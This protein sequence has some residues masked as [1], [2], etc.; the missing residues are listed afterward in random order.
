[1][2]LKTKN[3]IKD[4]LEEIEKELIAIKVLTQQD[5]TIDITLYHR[6]DERLSRMLLAKTLILDDLNN[7][8][9]VA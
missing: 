8:T 3:T 2:K 9:L 4:S 1:M 5:D 6:C 7:P